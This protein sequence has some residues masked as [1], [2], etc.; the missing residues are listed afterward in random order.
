MALPDVDEKLATLPVV[1]ADVL[2]TRFATG[3]VES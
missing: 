2:V 1:E 3:T